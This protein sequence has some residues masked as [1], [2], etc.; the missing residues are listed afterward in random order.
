MK[1]VNEETVS[2]VEVQP[3]LCKLG[4]RQLRLQA[5]PTGKCGEYFLQ[6]FCSQT[7]IPPLWCH[8]EMLDKGKFRELPHRDHSLQIICY[9]QAVSWLVE[10]SQMVL[11]GSELVRREALKQ[12]GIDI[13]KIR[14]RGDSQ[15]KNTS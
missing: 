4:F 9:V 8:C 11:E 5:Y 14:F 13:V 10:K 15:H 2:P 6:K 3:P 1:V 7:L 12:Q